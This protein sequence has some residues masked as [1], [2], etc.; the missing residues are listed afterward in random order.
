[1]KLET[2]KEGR[3]LIDDERQEKIKRQ[4][5]T[6]N[7]HLMKLPPILKAHDW[8]TDPGTLRGILEGGADYIK[9]RT[10]SDMKN[11][12]LKMGVFKEAV[13][14][15]AK[16]S[17]KDIPAE[18][19]KA[20]QDWRADWVDIIRNM[21][22]CKPPKNEEIDIKTG[23]LTVNK[24]YATKLHDNCRHLITPEE[25]KTLNELREAI[26]TIWRI[27]DSGYIVCDWYMNNPRTGLPVLQPG[28][29]ACL[30]GRG[31]QDRPNLTDVYTLELMRKYHRS[32]TKSE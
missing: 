18:M 6:L 32:E 26:E 1:M 20:V 31:S 25:E 24:E 11:V 21:Q 8:A 29:I 16:E 17:V 30:L 2:T 27:G 3:F 10:E 28:L 12:L 22:V 4:I 7:D 15:M 23:Y 13:A 14:R 5:G 9:E 19:L